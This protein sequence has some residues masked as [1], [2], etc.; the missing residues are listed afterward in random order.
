[1][2]KDWQ[3]KQFRNII[4]I[5]HGYPFKGEFFSASGKY[6]L[7]TP[8]NFFEAGGFKRVTAKDKYY[9][10]EFPEEYLHKKDDLIVAMTEQAEG[11]LGS[12][13]LVPEDNLYLHNQRLG[14]ITMNENE[15]DKKFIYYLFQMKYIRKQ[16]RLTSTGSKV[17]HTSPERIYDVELFL[18][19]FAEQQKIASILS[20]LDKK[21]AINNK[22]NNE[23]E[24]IAKTLYDY[25]FVQFDFPNAN[26]KPYKSSGGK[27]VY[28]EELK[29]EIPER[30]ETDLIS[31]KVQINSGYPFSSKDYLLNGKFRIIT[32]K[33]VQDGELLLNKVDYLDSMPEKLPEYCMLSIGDILISLTGNVGRMAIVDDY[34]LLLNQRVGKIVTHANYLYYSYLFF[35]RDEN[36]LRLEKIA[37]GSSQSNL[38]PLDAVDDYMAIPTEKILLKFNQRLNPIYKKMLSVKIENRKLT[39]LRDWLLPMLMN[40]QVSVADAKEQIDELMVAEPVQGYGES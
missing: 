8:G 2:N 36:R 7:L 4:D 14:H 33:N 5:K 10:G 19:P 27:M 20:A 11:L 18:P 32:I 1:M 26:G 24:A 35:L 13:A 23:L 17:K 38:S 31:S 6:V 22:I 28:S 29:R 9:I 37:G 39:Q 25:W 16:I 3:H 12:C 40:G 34:N 15:V 21:I 30:W